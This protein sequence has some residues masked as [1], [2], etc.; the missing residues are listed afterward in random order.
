VGLLDAA[1]PSVYLDYAGSAEIRRHVHGQLPALRYSCSIGAA[2]VDEIGS[3][4]GLPGPKP[5]FMFAPAQAAKR[6]AEWGPAGL[7][8]RMGR[9]WDAFVSRARD[10][11]DPWLVVQQHT[12]PEAAQAAWELVLAGRSEARAGHILSLA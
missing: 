10:P 7:M 4:E 9:D 3:A 8:E 6:S 5:I 1:T 12:G 2:H 11:Q